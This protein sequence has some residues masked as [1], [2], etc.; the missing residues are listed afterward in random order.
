[1]GVSDAL[2][3]SFRELGWTPDPPEP[4]VLIYH[5]ESR[6]S[7]VIECKAQSFTPASSTAQQGRKLLG[8][9]AEPDIAVGSP[10]GAGEAYVVYALPLEDVEEQQ[11]T[12]GALN[13]EV[14]EAGLSYAK[15]GTLGFEI[16]DGGLWAELAIP[17]ATEGS[18]I[19]SICKRVWVTDGDDG[20]ARP[21]YLVPYDPTAID[22]Q[23]PEEKE[24][25]TNL[26][27]QR[28][29]TH[30]MSMLG[31]AEVPNFVRIHAHD[32]LREATFQVSDYWQAS[33]LNK[34]QNRIA[35]TLASYLNKGAFKEK[36][37]L[38]GSCVEVHLENLGAQ[39]A[40]LAMLLKARTEVMAQ[41]VLDPQMAL[42]E[43][44]S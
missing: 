9:C 39:E 5:A 43:V 21:I 32:A 6:D 10:K 19:T 22:N 38:S 33:E 3:K 44:D 34:L 40:I 17:D 41:A 20:A 28:V 37:Q 27:V 8:V 35:R 7:L 14:A 24:Y 26:L 42:N 1:M 12:L 13:G 16:T 29:L 18:T 31:R 15:S 4:D 11:Q 23:E 36:V 25:C 2:K 30:A